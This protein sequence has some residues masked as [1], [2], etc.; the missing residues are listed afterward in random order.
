MRGLTYF[1]STWIL[2]F[3]VIY[4]THFT[5]LSVLLFYRRLVAGTV[6]KK[7]KL[8]IY[9]AIFFV[10]ASLI[11]FTVLLFVTC[12]PFTYEWTQYS[13]VVHQGVCVDT[14]TT[15]AG[16]VIQ[17]SFSVIS[18]LYSVLLPAA[19]LLRIRISKRQRW[20]LMFIFGL[21]FMLALPLVSFMMMSANSHA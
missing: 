14:N 2:E 12:K 16:A 8:A 11:I 5:K 4:S 9:L 20:G 17:G 15:I 3:F 18:D 10:V 6:S 7:F 21:G 19:L 1:E 13:T